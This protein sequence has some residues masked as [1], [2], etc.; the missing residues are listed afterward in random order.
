MQPRERPALELVGG[1]I[2]RSIFFFIGPRQLLSL[3]IWEGNMGR[4]ER[5]DVIVVGV[6]ERESSWDGCSVIDRWM[7]GGDEAR[8]VQ[9]LRQDRLVVT[10]RAADVAGT[11]ISD[12][13]LLYTAR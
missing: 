9:P 5:R 3:L 10:N 2:L 12:I 11:E 6:G 1:F 4:L 8:G 7:Y 13:Y